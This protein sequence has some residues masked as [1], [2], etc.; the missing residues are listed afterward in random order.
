MNWY[1]LVVFWVVI[2]VMIIVGIEIL[3]M[4][5]CI[6]GFGYIVG[7]FILIVGFFLIFFIWYKCDGNLS[8]DFI[9]W[10][11]VE[12]MFWIVVVFFNSFGMVFGDFLVD[13]VGFGYMNVVFV[14]IVVI[15]VVLVFYYIKMMNDIV[16]FWIV[17]IFIWFFGVIFGDFFIKFV[18]YGGF[19]FGIYNV[20]FVCLV[21]MMGLVFIIVCCRF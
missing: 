1:Y 6:F 15:V 5:D 12:I 19:D 16:L 21:L 10:K 17:F 18:V 2:V 14:C 7:L 11:D 20:L 9:V 13:N 4:M 8:V 3:D